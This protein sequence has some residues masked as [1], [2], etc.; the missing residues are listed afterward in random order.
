MSW[1]GRPAEDTK[2]LLDL[3]TMVMEIDA[4][5]E[6]VLYLLGDGDEDDD[7]GRDA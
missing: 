6:R 7:E 4:K 1:R 5:L 3:A 2:L